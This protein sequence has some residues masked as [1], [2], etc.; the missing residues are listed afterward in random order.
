[1]EKVGRDRPS[2]SLNVVAGVHSHVEEPNTIVVESVYQAR[3]ATN[4][5]SPQKSSVQIVRAKGKMTVVE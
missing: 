1:M 2:T 5:E 3:E 4:S